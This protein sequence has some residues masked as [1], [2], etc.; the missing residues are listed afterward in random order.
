MKDGPGVFLKNQTSL[1]E[2]NPL[3]T[4]LEQRHAKTCLQIPHLLR[5]ARLRNSQAV[6][7]PAEISRFGDREK[8]AEV[9]DVQGL[10]HGENILSGTPANCNQELDAASVRS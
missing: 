3:P 2:Q 7:G 4:A 5:H 8:I 6:S 1:G 9:A 10:R